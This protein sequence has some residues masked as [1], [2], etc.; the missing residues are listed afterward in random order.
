MWASCSTPCST[1]TGWAAVRD[2]LAEVED[3]AAAAFARV[4]R[5]LRAGSLPTRPQR[6]SAEGAPRRLFGLAFESRPPPPLPA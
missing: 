3:Y 5:I 2:W 4:I 1:S 6:P